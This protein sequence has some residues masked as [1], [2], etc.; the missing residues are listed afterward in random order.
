MK[1]WILFPFIY[2]TNL[3]L[4]KSSFYVQSCSTRNETFKLPKL[5][6]SLYDLCQT[7]FYKK[8]FVT[9]TLKTK[10]Y[11]IMQYRTRH[12]LNESNRLSWTI[13]TIH[14]APKEENWFVLKY[15][16]PTFLIDSLL[17]F[18]IDSFWNMYLVLLIVS[19]INIY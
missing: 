16:V 5:M 12:R 17:T 2:H 4:R 7:Y 6:S 13:V 18:L 15:F 3:K 19:F 1:T 14:S 11:D 9:I 8:N 10:H